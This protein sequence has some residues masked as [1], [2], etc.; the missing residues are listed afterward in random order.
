MLGL[1]KD[2]ALNVIKQVGNYGEVY[3]NF[4]G[5]KT[6][7]GLERGINALYTDGGLIYAPPMR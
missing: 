6:P 2:W 7:I 3:E 1:E 5:A 4:I